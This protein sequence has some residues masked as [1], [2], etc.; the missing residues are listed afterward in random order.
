MLHK[1]LIFSLV[2]IISFSSNA[3][4]GTDTE[5]F[6]LDL[7]DPNFIYL[8]LIENTRTKYYYS[9]K[10]L[11]IDPNQPP[12][13]GGLLVAII[14]VSQ[15]YRKMNLTARAEAANPNGIFYDTRVA[16]FSI[17]CPSKSYSPYIIYNLQDSKVVNTHKNS[18]LIWT[19][20]NISTPMGKIMNKLINQVCY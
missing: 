8:G 6:A 15:N 14:D 4:S 19:T 17:N 5:Y 7:N 10:S 11:T 1:L 20:V 3:Y 18:S 13:S 2:F 12:N 16:Q 9:R